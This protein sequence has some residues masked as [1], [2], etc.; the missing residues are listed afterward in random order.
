MTVLES[1]IMGYICFVFGAAFSY[2]NAPWLALV[3]LFGTLG[4]LGHVIYHDH[5]TNLGGGPLSPA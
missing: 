1:R 4:F 3:F 2:L 5:F